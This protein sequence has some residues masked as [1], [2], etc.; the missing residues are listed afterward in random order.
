MKAKVRISMF[1][2]SGASGRAAGSSTA[3]CAL[4]RAR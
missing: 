4:M 2:G 1:S 3:E